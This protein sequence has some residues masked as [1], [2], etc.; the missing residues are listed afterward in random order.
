MTP[1]NASPI[2][3]NALV[4]AEAEALFEAASR[5]LKA[6]DIQLLRQAFVTARDAHEGQTRK[7]G[8]P[9][10]THP[11]AVAGILTE[12]R[13][14]AQGLAAALMHD[15]MDDC[16]ISRA[17]TPWPRPPCQLCGFSGSA[18]A[19][20][21]S[22]RQPSRSSARS[23]LSALNTSGEKSSSRSEGIKQ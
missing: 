21:S 14:D 19:R 17:D 16:G 11:L 15:V 2:D 4:D 5:Y 22:L 3:Y 1:E 18:I 8:E 12:W 10:I 9:Y 6:E 13:L 7:S 20:G 23:G